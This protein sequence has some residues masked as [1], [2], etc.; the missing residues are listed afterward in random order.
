VG[1][2]RTR[3]PPPQTADG[4]ALAHDPGYHDGAMSTAEPAAA[5]ATP[6]AIW[7][8]LDPDTRSRAA[9]ALFRHAASDPAMRQEALHAIAAALRF[10]EASVRKLP[11]DKRVEYLVRVVRPDDSLASSLL[12]A[13]HVVERAPM[14]AA[15]LDALSIPHDAG[16]IDPRYEPEPPAADRL[17]AAIRTLRVTFPEAEVDLYLASLAAMDPETWR[18]LV[19]IGRPSR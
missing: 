9:R 17:E 12:L 5:S 7:S 1:A 14:L 6:A 11:L 18:G 10:R 19:E 4:A 3:R 8:K 13:L 16:V 2:R 15:F